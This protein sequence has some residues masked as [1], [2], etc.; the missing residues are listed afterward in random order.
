M[1][2]KIKNSNTFVTFEDYNG[3]IESHPALAA[4]PDVYELTSDE[5]NEE[6]NF[7][8]CTYKG[9]PRLAPDYYL[10]R[11]AVGKALVNEVANELL[12][13]YKSGELTLIQ[14]MEMEQTLENTM[15]ALGRGQIIS[16]LYH[17]SNV[18]N[19]DTNFKASI[20]SRIQAL[21]IAHYA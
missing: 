19:I 2:V 6:S 18:S 10:T 17:I 12:I 7:F 8:V 16:A 11:E 14:V 13:K 4:F 3:A 5:P 9:D 21:K 20:A 15:S 1:N